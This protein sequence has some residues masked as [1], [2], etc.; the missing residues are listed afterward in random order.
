[1]FPRFES[2]KDA[3]DLIPNGS[4]F[5]KDFKLVRNPHFHRLVFSFL[6]VVYSFQGQFTDFG[7]FRRRVKWISGSFV[8]YMIDDKMITELS[9]W[10]FSSMGDMEFQELYKRIKTACWKNFYP[11]GDPDQVDWMVKELLRFD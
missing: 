4:L 1:M 3:L 8:E 7:L 5:V 2:D 10:D 9:S 11:D 6:N